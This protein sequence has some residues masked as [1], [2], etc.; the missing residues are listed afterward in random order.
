MEIEEANQTSSRKD[1]KVVKTCKKCGIQQNMRASI[2]QK[3]RKATD[4]GKNSVKSAGILT[5][6]KLRAKK[7]NKVYITDYAAIDSGYF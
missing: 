1:E 2:C 5:I 6:S 3:C 7:P 4:A